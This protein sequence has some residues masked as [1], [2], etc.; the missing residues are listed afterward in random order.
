MRP[1]RATIDLAALGH[2]LREVR[3]R[4]GTA[5]VLGIVKADAYGHGALLIAPALERYGIDWLGVALTEEGIELREAGLRTPLLILDGAYGQAYDQLLAHR[6]TPVVFRLDHLDGLSAAAVRVGQP[7]QAHLKV[8]TGMGRLGVL[9]EEVADFAAAAR[10]RGV[11]LTGLCTHFANAD[12]GDAE[13]TRK[14][15]ERFAAATARVRDAGHQP[16]L[17]HLSNSAAVI[18]NTEAHGTLVRPGLMLYGHVPAARLATA[19]DLRPVLRWTTEVLQVKQVPAGTKVS[20]GGRFVCTRESRLATLAVGYADGFRRDFSGRVEVL[21]RGQR[22][23]VLGV[24]T[25]DLCVADVT[26]VSGVAVGD[27]V[28]LLGGQGEETITLEELARHGDTIAYEV[29]C[30]ISSRVPRVAAG[31]PAGVL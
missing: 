21:V 11:V 14:Q 17:I 23:P 30:G 18:E 6:L 19:V 5:L 15:M 26:E 31:V 3:K 24:I 12:L 16:T 29:L 27:E 20:Y 10:A 8:D 13:V 7:A 9:L 4:V 2:N 25:M 22:A 1:T 28:V